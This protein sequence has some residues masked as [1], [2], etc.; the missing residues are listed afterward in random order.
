MQS[1]NECDWGRGGHLLQVEERAAAGRARHE[2]GLGVAH[3][4]ALQQ[5]EG[6]GAQEVEV[7]VEARRVAD[8]HTFPEAVHQQRPHGDAELQREVE[9]LNE[10]AESRGEP[11]FTTDE[12]RACFERTGE[13]NPRASF[14]DLIEQL[15]LENYILKK[16]PGRYKLQ[17]SA[18]S[19]RR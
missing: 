19:Q 17:T 15:N 7:E 8:G 9:R 3:A 14:A 18:V 12:L 6:G 13:Q 5:A 1:A 2:L 10:E 4:A 11:H 16:G